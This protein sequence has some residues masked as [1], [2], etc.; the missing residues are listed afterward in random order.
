RQ[1]AVFAGSW[2]LQAAEAVGAS[3]GGEEVMQRLGSL[4][5]KSLLR[6]TWL[7]PDEPRF[8]MLETI[9]EYARRLLAEAGDEGVARQRLAAY[10]RGLAETAEAALLG[11]D[12]AAWLALLASEQDNIRAVLAW[13]LE[14]S[15]IELGLAITSAIW[16]F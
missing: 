1:L 4:V 6:R 7:D 9:R 16:H 5:E 14:V 8:E 12:H 3:D 11:I 2:T 10:Y 15:Q 13:T